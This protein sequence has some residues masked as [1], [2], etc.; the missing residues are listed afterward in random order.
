MIQ[1]TYLNKYNF[2]KTL[3]EKRIKNIQ[4]L[5]NICPT[6]E[7]IV[8]KNNDLQASSYNSSEKCDLSFISSKDKENQCNEILKKN[9]KTLKITVIDPGATNLFKS[10]EFL[11]TDKGLVGS[12]RDTNVNEVLIG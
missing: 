10:H 4:K 8:N 9:Y 5:N 7:I 1:E 3:F 6:Q 2:G 11:I 12:T